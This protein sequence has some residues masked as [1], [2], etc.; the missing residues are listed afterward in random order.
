MAEI[1]WCA[2]FLRLVTMTI[3]TAMSYQPSQS[4]MTSKSVKLEIWSMVEVICTYSM[5]VTKH[6]MSRP[7]PQSFLFHKGSYRFCSPLSPISLAPLYLSLSLSHTRVEVF[8]VCVGDPRMRTI[9]SPLLIVSDLWELAYFDQW[10]FLSHIYLWWLVATTPGGCLSTHQ[11]WSG[12]STLSPYCL[13]RVQMWSYWMKTVVSLIDLPLLWFPSLLI[14][15]S[16]WVAQPC[17]VMLSFSLPGRKS[18]G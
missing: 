10:I 3:I 11:M 15:H 12:V 2:V 6:C 4:T 7:V 16:S 5:F 17:L 14:G 9:F 13:S 1:Q 18:S 8:E